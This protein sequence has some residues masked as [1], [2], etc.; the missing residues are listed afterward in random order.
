[1]GFLKKLKKRNDRYARIGKMKAAKKDA[2]A[3]RLEDVGIRMRFCGKNA[4]DLA[5]EIAR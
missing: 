3:E 2:K 5:K 1:M 4:M